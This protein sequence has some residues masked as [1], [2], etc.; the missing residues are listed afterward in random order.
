[1]ERDKLFDGSLTSCLKKMTK[2]KATRHFLPPRHLKK[3]ISIAFHILS[4]DKTSYL[5]LFTIYIIALMLGNAS[6]LAIQ[7]TLDK[8]FS[9]SPHQIVMQI[10]ANMPVNLWAGLINTIVIYTILAALKR[11]DHK[12]QFSDL[13][14]IKNV[15]S[16]NFVSSCLILHL[17][18]SSPLLISHALLLFNITWTII[19]W[20]FGFFLNYLFALGQFLIIEDP[21]ISL[22]SC[23]VWSVAASFSPE[24]IVTI[25]LTHAV[26]FFLYPY[27]ITVPFCII[28]QITTFYEVFGYSRDENETSYL[29]SPSEEIINDQ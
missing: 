7:W 22:T 17:I 9:H 12:I 8:S 27:L 25:M 28:L 20:L 2:W 10:T 15:V 14:S 18:L 26:V 13:L 6:L 1:M 29:R 24:T 23:L 3:R 5:I 19:Y 11:P 4:R 21:S 16:L